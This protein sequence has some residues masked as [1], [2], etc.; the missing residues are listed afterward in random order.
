M[1]P[2][3]E[4]RSRASRNEMSRACSETRRSNGGLHAGNEASIALD[5]HDCACA[6]VAPAVNAATSR[7]K[8]SGRDRVVGTVRSTLGPG[9]R[10][11]RP[12]KYRD[13]TLPLDAGT[14]R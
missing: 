2:S 3:V 11:H 7:M 8:S 10:R 9:P 4:M 6:F 5:T 13:V 1:R 12:V 14:E